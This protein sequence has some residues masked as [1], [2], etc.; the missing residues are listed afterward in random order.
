MRRGRAGGDTEGASGL[1]DGGGAVVRS[2]DRVGVRGSG[3]HGQG[4]GQ[5]LL[6][7]GTRAGAA[8]SPDLEAAEQP[9]PDARGRGLESLRQATP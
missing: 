2:S 1:R 5:G 3:C 6:P 9:S 4:G 7:A 8:G